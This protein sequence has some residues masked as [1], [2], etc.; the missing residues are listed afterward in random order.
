MDGFWE[1]PNCPERSKAR[2]KIT[3][4]RVPPILVIQLK[5]FSGKLEK[6]NTLV[7]FPFENLDMRPYVDNN[8]GDFLYD[9][10]AFIEHRGCLQN[11]HYTAFCRIEKDKW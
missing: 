7:N 4:D 5:R 9:L 10:F 8:S 2:K 6:I 11:G 3:F 1:C